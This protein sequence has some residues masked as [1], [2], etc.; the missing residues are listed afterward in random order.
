MEY[1]LKKNALKER[2][3]FREIEK[4]VTSDD[5]ALAHTLIERCLIRWYAQYQIPPYLIL[6]QL[7]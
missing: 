7:R 5:D 6:S 1:F 3:E 4:T 2:P